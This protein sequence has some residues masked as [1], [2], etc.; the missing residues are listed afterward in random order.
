MSMT[1][2]SALVGPN[3]IIQTEAALSAFGGRSLAQAVFD[4]AGLSDFLKAPPQTMVAERDVARLMMALHN[5]LPNPEAACISRNAGNLTGRYILTHRIPG[6]IKALLRILPARYAGLVLL[7]AIQKHAWTFSGSGRTR[8]EVGAVLAFEIRDN[9][10]AMLGC[11]WHIGVFE[12]LFR[13][14]VHQKTV[15]SHE[16]CCAGRDAVCR[17]TFV[18]VV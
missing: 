6:P 14:L 3:A 15:V 2:A 1:S 8:Y 12:T 9:P 17:F 4:R 5:I 10:L 11:Y 7:R 18:I 16:T 13:V